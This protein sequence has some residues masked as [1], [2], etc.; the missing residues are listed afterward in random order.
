MLTVVRG[1]L[2]IHY[3]GFKD[4]LSV[5][6]VGCGYMVNVKVIELFVIYATIV[7]IKSLVVLVGRLRIIW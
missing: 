6:K 7:E 4:E 1:A 3:F 2:Q 5:K